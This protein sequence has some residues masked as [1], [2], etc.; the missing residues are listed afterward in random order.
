M[1]HVAVATTL[2][3][4]DCLWLEKMTHTHAKKKFNTL[5]N[6]QPQI[7]AKE[8]RASFHL[9]TIHT[10]TVANT[11]RERPSSQTATR[12]LSSEGPVIHFLPFCKTRRAQ[13]PN[14]PRLLSTSCNSWRNMSREKRQLN[15]TFAAS[16]SCKKMAIVSPDPCSPMTN[17]ASLP[18]FFRSPGILLNHHEQTDQGTCFH[19]FDWDAGTKPTQL[20][21]DHRLFLPLS[22]PTKLLPSGPPV[23]SL[24]PQPYSFLCKTHT[25]LP[26]LL[27]CLGTTPEGL[28][29][30]VNQGRAPSFWFNVVDIYQCLQSIHFFST[31]C[32]LIRALPDYHIRAPFWHF[33]LSYFKCCWTQR[34]DPTSRARSLSTLMNFHASRP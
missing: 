7:P 34:S 18:T 14:Q 9:L 25:F 4:L 12:Q 22:W 10:N 5:K 11:V 27:R 33:R 2:P 31:Q 20:A 23:A 19:C 8:A 6:S 28:P 13:N 32:Q 1:A 26:N 3:V 29:V 24:L 17:N 21:E 15:A 16:Q 30:R